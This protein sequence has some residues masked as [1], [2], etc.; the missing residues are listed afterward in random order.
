MKQSVSSFSFSLLAG[1][2]GFSLLLTS[3]GG[4]DEGQPNS[5]IASAVAV[6]SPTDGHSAS[7]TVTFTAREDGQVDIVAELTGLKP[8]SFHGFHIHEYGDVTAP[9]G[10]SAGGHY[11]PRGHKHGTPGMGEHHAGDLG[12][13]ASDASGNARKEMTVDFISIDGPE[14]PILGRG[15]I[16]H[17]GEDD[18]VSQPTG[19]AGA[20]IASGVIGV[21]NPE[22]SL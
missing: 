6:L 15:V 4:R 18:L 10:T 21:A 7:G 1:I 11:A 8:N 13:V 22:T 2:L 5:G 16:L 3:C 19:A 14:A 20:R 12:N 9:D 17:A